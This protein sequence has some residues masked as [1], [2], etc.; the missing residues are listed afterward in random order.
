LKGTREVICR[1][2]RILNKIIHRFFI[3]ILRSQKAMGWY[4]Q[5][6]ERKENGNQ[7]SSIWQICLSKVREK[8]IPR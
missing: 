6:T 8:L 7:A 1:I 4:V 2:Q 3:R 5:S